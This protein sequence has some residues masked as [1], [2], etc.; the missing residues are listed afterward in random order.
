LTHHL[1]PGANGLYRRQVDPPHQGVVMSNSTVVT[2]LLRGLS[3]HCPNCGKGP[4]LHAYLK[5]T[6][7]CPAC[8]HDNA[9]YPSD[10]APPYF[11]ILL[12]GH[13]VVAPM[14]LLP[15]IWA[16]P[17]AVLVSAA[18]GLVLTASLVLLPRVKG[19]VIGLQWAIH[20]GDSASHA[21][22]VDEA[23]W[24]PDPAAETH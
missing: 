19:A 23:D 4:L 8:G 17:T 1:Q 14:L 22:L 3:G 21:S 6:S 20:E 2:G 16:W 18:L 11:T 24:T 5:V 10:D 7:P 12:V 15:F 13:L 9:Q